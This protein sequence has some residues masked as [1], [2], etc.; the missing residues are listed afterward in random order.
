MFYHSTNGW[1]TTDAIRISNSATNV[2]KIQDGKVGIGLQGPSGPISPLHVEGNV[3]INNGT[4]DV[5]GFAVFDD[6]VSVNSLTIN[7]YDLPDAKPTPPGGGSIAGF[8][9]QFNGSGELEWFDPLSVAVSAPWQLIDTDSDGNIDGMSPSSNSYNVGLGIDPVIGTK[10]IVDGSTVLGGDVGISNSGKLGIGIPNPDYSLEVSGDGKISGNVG[11]GTNP[12][13]GTKLK[14]DGSTLIGGGTIESSA[15]MQINSTSKGILIPRMSSYDR[16]NILDAVEGLMIYQTD[17]GKGFYW[18]DGSTWQSQNHNSLWQEGTSN[19]SN[20]EN[21]NGGTGDVTII[22]SNM[23]IEKSADG[24][25][26]D[27]SIIGGDISIQKNGGSGGALTMNGHFD[28]TNGSGSSMFAVNTSGNTVI[29]GTTTM[30]SSATI[31]GATIITNTLNVSGLTTISGNTVL[32]GTGGVT[33]GSSNQYILPS[34]KGTDGQVLKVPASG[35]ELEWG[36]LNNTSNWD[37]EDLSGDGNI[38]FLEP[39][40]ENIAVG[41]GTNGTSNAKFE[42]KSAGNAPTAIFNNVDDDVILNLIPHTNKRVD[43][44]MGV[45]SNPNLGLI[46]YDNNDAKM[47]FWANNTP[48]FELT[49]F[50]ITANKDIKINSSGNPANKNTLI[51]TDLGDG[52]GDQMVKVT[53]SGELTTAP[54]PQNATTY[55]TES[56][57]VIGNNNSGMVDI[58]NDFYVGGQST[59]ND[60]IAVMGGGITLTSAGGFGGFITT[61]KDLLVGNNVLKAVTSE[62]KVAI[63]NSSPLS[64]LSIGNEAEASFMTQQGGVSITIADDGSDVYLETNSGDVSEG[65]LMHGT[66][67]V[68]YYPHNNYSGIIKVIDASTSV[69]MSTKE[70]NSLYVFNR[71]SEPIIFETSNQERMRING[72]GSIQFGDPSG[73]SPTHYKFPTTIGNDG[74]V[75]AV[76]GTTANTLE[77]TTPSSGSWTTTAGAIYTNSHNV[78]IGTTNPDHPFEIVHTTSTLDN[79]AAKITYTSTGS[80]IG[81]SI[82]LS[83]LA[84]SSS[85]T[86]HGINS[87]VSISGSIDGVGIGGY[88]DGS[89]SG[90]HIGVE[91]GSEGSSGTNISGNFVTYSANNS[92]VNYGIKAYNYVQGSASGTNYGIWAKSTK[93]IGGSGNN[94]GIYAAADG[95]TNNYAGYFADGDVK[96]ENNLELNGDLI[97]GNSGQGYMFTSGSSNSDKM[98][99]G[100]SEQHPNWGL[101]YKDVG[102]EFVFLSGGSEKVK[103]SLTGSPVLKVTG[104]SEITGNLTIEGEVNTSYGGAANMVAIAYANVA[105]NGTINSGSGNIS[106][107]KVPQTNGEYEI[108]VQKNGTAISLNV[109]DYIISLNTTMHSGNT[110]NIYLENGNGGKILVKTKAGMNSIHYDTDFTIV[111]YKP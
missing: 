57:G 48:V 76:S 106:V 74:Q 87:R 28:I 98:I 92:G 89:S 20:I 100:H 24:D 53:P 64:I 37:A 111:I 22:G 97:F 58:Q 13:S 27:L 62:G 69:F 75:L 29:N 8:Q 99:L 15:I 16:A 4:L 82:G 67:G 52:A 32:S 26:G 109:T 60:N 6:N 14:V 47:E 44:T 66:S 51:I 33:I 41:I 1:E 80:G 7:D 12:V 55:W 35:N 21:T 2:M 73:Q 40:D 5:D 19:S 70:D 45:L 42:V 96:I 43:I 63:G 30:N 103:I 36:D 95:G 102:D 59:F 54:M 81:N 34:T 88:A 108:E 90:D 83:I 72:A 93:S 11:I 46:R 56:S 18:F 86:T 39:S 94:Y 9:L 25:G 79:P 31:T 61:E 65:L 91:G 101:Q 68:S 104:N 23:F 85:V 84:S 49:S 77:W 105:A 78:G 71:S 10:L 50:D 38:D 3:Q 107:T 17:N 110:R